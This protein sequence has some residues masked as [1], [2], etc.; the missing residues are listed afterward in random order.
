MEIYDIIKLLIDREFLLSMREYMSF[1]DEIK[2]VVETKG[3]LSVIS[4]LDGVVAEYRFGEGVHIQNNVAGVFENKRPLYTIIKL[5]HT[6]SN[7]KGVELYIASSY[8]FEEQRIEKNCWV[9]KNMPFV[10][11]E[12]RIFVKRD[13]DLGDEVTKIRAINNQVIK[14]SNLTFLIDDSHVILFRAIEELGDKIRAF[15]ISSLIE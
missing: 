3:T 2:Q 8:F 14:K 1:I 7:I 13:F 11:L 10:K 4:D 12:N 15:H 6:V 9:E 5:L